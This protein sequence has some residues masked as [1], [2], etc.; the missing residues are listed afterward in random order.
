MSI[1]ARK[2]IMKSIK[3]IFLISALA[4]ILSVGFYVLINS[5]MESIAEADLFK[6]ERSAPD[7]QLCERLIRFGQVA[8]DRGRFAEAKHFFQKAITVDPANSAA[9]RKYNMALLA[10]ISARVESDPGFLPQWALQPGN[11]DSPRQSP[12][13]TTEDDDGC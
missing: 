5:H 2:W 13:N 4:S 6:S 9:W 11:S 10:L 7:P 12:S 8:Y 1:Q 3:N